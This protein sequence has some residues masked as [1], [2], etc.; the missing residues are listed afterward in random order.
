MVRTVM[1]GLVLLFVGVVPSSA[2]GIPKPVWQG[3]VASYNDWHSTMATLIAKCPPAP[4][5]RH[6]DAWDRWARRCEATLTTKA[7][8]NG[9]GLVE[10]VQRHFHV[11]NTEIA[12]CLPCLDI[13]LSRPGSAALTDGRDGPGLQTHMAHPGFFCD[14]DARYPGK[15][16]VSAGPFQDRN[17]EEGSQRNPGRFVLDISGWQLS[18][19]LYAHYATCT[20]KGKYRWA[21]DLKKHFPDYLPMFK[22]AFTVW[23]RQHPE[24]LKG[25]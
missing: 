3:I 25:G 10:T 23:Y 18:C 15:E 2:A 20:T 19:D 17:E 13:S 21:V 16:F 7:D 11:V 8:V 5:S 24:A 9:D 14:V 1:L 4:S 22:D 6:D 12:D